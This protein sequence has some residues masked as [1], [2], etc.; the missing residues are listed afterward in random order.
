FSPLND[1]QNNM[2][3]GAAG[4]NAEP[5]RVDGLIVVGSASGYAIAP[6]FIVTNYHVVEHGDQFLISH[7]DTL[8]T[9]EV[10]TVVATS[11]EKD[12]AL[13]KCEK[14]KFAPLQFAGQLPRLASDLVVCGYPESGVL[15]DDL[16]VTRGS[17]VA[18]PN[19]EAVDNLMYD[20][21]TNPGNSGGP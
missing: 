10:A 18:H 1:P 17:V 3:G 8:K 4:K 6:Q 14:A 2:P 5:A 15:G 16:K 20:A 13:L 9:A 11:K 12:L 21:V 19:R 7:R